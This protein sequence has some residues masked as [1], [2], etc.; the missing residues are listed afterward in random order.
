MLNN[1]I[2]NND[3]VDH[4]GD[5][6]SSNYGDVYD[7]VVYVGNKNIHISRPLLYSLRSDSII[8]SFIFSSQRKVLMKS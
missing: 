5:D 1:N 8:H 6:D 3:G 7:M 2:G 4:N